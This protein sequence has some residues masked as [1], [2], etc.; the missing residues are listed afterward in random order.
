MN[1]EVE[2]SNPK[3]LRGVWIGLTIFFTVALVFKLIQ[4]LRGSETW[5]GILVPA[6]FILLGITQ[7]L[8]LKGMVQKVLVVLSAL[9]AV[10]SL[11]MLF[12]R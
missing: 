9:L 7:I 3:G 5:D 12:I 1:K 6:V 4:W 2:P 8:Q 11:V 10:L